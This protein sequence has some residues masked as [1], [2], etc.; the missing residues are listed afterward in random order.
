MRGDAAGRVWMPCVR[1]GPAPLSNGGRQAATKESVRD[2]SLPGRRRSCGSVYE[3]PT[4]RLRAG[5]P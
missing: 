2:R 1:E 3:S 5:T 4:P